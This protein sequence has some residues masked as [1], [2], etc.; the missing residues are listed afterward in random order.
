[1]SEYQ[2]VLGVVERAVKARATAKNQ[3][4]TK[5]VAEIDLALKEMGVECRLE[6]KYSWPDAP[7]VKLTGNVLFKVLE[8]ATGKVAAKK[9]DTVKVRYIGY[10]YNTGK[11]FDAGFIKFTLGQSE[12][13]RGWDIGLIGMRLN[14]K[15]RLK[16]PGDM[17]YGAQGAPPDIPPDA[18]L[19]FDLEL[20][21]I[22]P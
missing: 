1:M 9:G 19:L 13:I 12:V 7:Q 2:E 6:T 4:K 5:L 15:R 3:K 21:K 10:L 18:T 11:K 22:L 14:E 8:P 17:A 16:I 20:L